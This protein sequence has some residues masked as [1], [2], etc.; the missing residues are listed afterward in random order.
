MEVNP[1]QHHA[2][3]IPLPGNSQSCLEDQLCVLRSRWG[4]WGVKGRSE[5]GRCMGSVG[6]K[7]WSAWGV[8]GRSEGGG[9]HG[10]C[11]GGVRVEECMGRVEE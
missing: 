10:E 2:T 7:G 1:K 9:G 8:W 5:G 3:G 4:V 6:E 11:G